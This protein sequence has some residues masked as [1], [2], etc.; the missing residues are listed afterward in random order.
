MGEQDDL[1]QNSSLSRHSWTFIL[2]DTLP[3]P[4]LG[5]KILTDAQGLIQGSPEAA[6]VSHAHRGWGG[7]RGRGVDGDLRGKVLG[8]S[9]GLGLPFGGH[10]PS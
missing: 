9:P 1:F 8:G 6:L 4:L 10:C 2:K 3:P 5:V 7:G